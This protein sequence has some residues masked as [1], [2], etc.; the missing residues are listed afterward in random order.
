MSNPTTSHG[1]I[2]P[3]VSVE[4]LR[5]NYSAGTQ[6]GPGGRVVLCD[7][8]YY[9]DGRDGMDAY[10]AGH[11]P[12]AVFIDMDGVLASPAG[13]VVGR[14]PMP[15]PEAFA[16]GL[17]AAG[18]S[19]DDTV[20]VYDDL[21]GMVAGRL[22][23]MLRILGQHSALLDGG[24]GAWDGPLVT[25]PSRPTSV[26]CA[27][28]PWPEGAMVSADEA[29]ALAAGGGVLADSRAVERYRGETEPID[30]RAGHIPGAICL[31]FAANLDADGRFKSPEEL[32]ARFAEVGVDANAVFYCGSG[33]SA[34]HN[35]LAVE[36]AGL[37]LPRLYV[38][39]W[40]GWSSDPDRP[41]A[42]GPLP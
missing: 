11:L 41:A 6:A 1:L 19:P 5:A 42:T 18:I 26:P 2:E 27:V 8:R 3:L 37:G 10:L 7:V 22:V 24:I 4:W 12:G 35:L 33:V 39:S 30:P 20:I 34:C 21:G 38:G 36:A 40:S 17:G 23:W 15:T 13:P 32:R 9:L 29:L 25:S 14:H 16:A 28:R 31:P